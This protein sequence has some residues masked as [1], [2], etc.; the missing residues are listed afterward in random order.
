MLKASET[1]TMFKK[2]TTMMWMCM[3][4]MFILLTADGR[5]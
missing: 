2:H 3:F 4:M 5:S 1:K